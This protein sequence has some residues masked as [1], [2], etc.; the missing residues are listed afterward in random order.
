MGIFKHKKRKTKTYKV[1]EYIGLHQPVL[2]KDILSALFT[3]RAY[4]NGT[5][6]WPCWSGIR[7]ALTGYSYNSNP[8][9]IRIKMTDLGYVLTDYGK[10]WL[11]LPLRPY[12]YKK[13]R[14]LRRFLFDYRKVK[15][16]VHYHLVMFGYKV[17]ELWGNIIK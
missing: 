2:A 7:G 1:V 15:F 3:K 11:Q 16:N 8:A 12:H 13:P 10:Q 4:D 5:S 14:W 6:N 17:R 9:K